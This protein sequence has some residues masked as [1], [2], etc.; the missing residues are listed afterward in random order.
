MAM[1]DVTGWKLWYANGVTVTSLTTAWNKAPDG[2]Q[3]LVLFHAGG[4]RTFTYGEDLYNLPAQA[5]R[6]AKPGIW[7]DTPA[8]YALVQQAFDDPQR[9]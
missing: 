1:L 9:M 3:V 2:V 4:Y 8:F 5:S 6:F 7:M